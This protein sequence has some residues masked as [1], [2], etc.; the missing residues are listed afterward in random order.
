MYL[1]Y[2]QDIVAT[3]SFGSVSLSRSIYRAQT[4]LETR[5]QKETNDYL[6]AMTAY[7]LA[8]AKS[9]KA[10]QLLR[11]LRSTAIVDGKV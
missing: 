11:K 7:A 2:L 5:S 3:C 8:L 4:Y 9:S 1:M 6:H 10:K